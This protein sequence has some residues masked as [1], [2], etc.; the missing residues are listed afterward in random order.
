MNRRARDFAQAQPGAGMGCLLAVLLH[1][2]ATASAAPAPLLA[3][4]RLAGECG[5]RVV[6]VRKHIAAVDDREHMGRLD[7]L[8]VLLQRHGVLRD[9]A[10]REATGARLCGGRDESAAE[11]AACWVDALV[12]AQEALI[13][14]ARLGAAR[15]P[16][17]PHRKTLTAKEEAAL[18]A[19]AEA[20]RTRAVAQVVAAL[21]PSDRSITE[22]VEGWLHTAGP[23]RWSA[24]Q[25]LVTGLQ[26]YRTLA[27]QAPPH[28]DADFPVAARTA[29]HKRAQRKDWLRRLSPQH[30]A[31]LRQRLCF[32]GYCP[33][34]AVSAEGLAPRLT[35]AGVKAGGSLDQKL[36]AALRAWQYDRGLRPA[37]LV[38]ARTLAALRVSM[39][40]RVEQIRLSLQRMRDTGVGQSDVFLVANIPAFRVDVWREGKLA[41]SHKTQVGKGSRRVRRA[42]R[43]VR[44]PALRTPL[45]STRLRYL[46]L[47][48]EWN[49][50]SSIRREY[51]HKVKKDPDWFEKNG[52]EQRV[53]SNG[54]ESLVMKS[55]PQN[56]LG[57]VKFLFPNQHLVYLHDTPSQA[58]FNLPVRLRS[59]GCV[60]VQDAPELARD[61]LSADRGRRVTDRQWRKLMD[62]AVDK[63]ISLRRPPAIHLVYWT[64]DANDQGRVRFYPDPYDYDGHDQAI[65]QQVALARLDGPPESSRRMPAGPATPECPGGQVGP[66]GDC[67]TR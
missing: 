21:R 61:L 40:E 10:D 4:S 59:H 27:S 64:A 57:V 53:S 47:N 38:D 20:R 28:L 32:E 5:L 33:P 11:R 43:L 44:I 54:G 41:R 3:E 1:L 22:V 30:R 42:G 65:A 49:V 14:G 16:L 36:T 15:Q 58:A 46:V 2:P 34:A 56:L 52:F 12:W 37:A 60:R 9:D 25:G 23:G 7:R 48:P 18:L 6:E 63:W 8:L 45:M 24:Y 13:D 62:G 67:P 66:D 29:W 19:K 55:G 17:P 50:P 35:P 31:Q 51:R 39:S 26:R